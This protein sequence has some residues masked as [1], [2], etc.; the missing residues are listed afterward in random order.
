MEKTYHIYAPGK[1]KD[2]LLAMLSSEKRFH[3]V[4]QYLDS[5]IWDGKKRLDWLLVDYLGAED[6]DYVHAVT[7]KTFSAA[8][9]RIYQ[10]GIKFDTILVLIEDRGLVKTLCSLKWGNTGIPIH[11]NC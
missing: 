3:P 7:R 8:A 4:R 11:D 10:P 1:C 9:A 6:T 2:A 5:Q